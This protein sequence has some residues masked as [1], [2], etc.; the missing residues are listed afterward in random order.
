MEEKFFKTIE[1]APV[2]TIFRHVGADSD[3]LGSQF[4]LKTWICDTY[5]DKKVYA[6][7]EDIGSCASQYPSIDHID[8][9]TIKTSLA[10]ILDTA[11]TA[12]IDDERWI[13][14]TQ[15]MKIDHHIQVEKF[16]N[17]QIVKEAAGATCEIIATIFANHHEKIS[18][19]CAT[20][21]YSGLIADTLQFSIATTT[22]NTLRAAAYLADFD[23]DIPSIN[24]QNFTKSKKE[25]VYETYLRSHMVMKGEHIAYCIVT[26]K[27]YES[28]NLTLN[29]A[30]EKVYAFA[31]VKEFEIWALFVENG[32]DENGEILFNGSLRSA[33][34]PI[35]PIAN[36]YHGGGHKLACGVKSLHAPEIESLLTELVA[37]IA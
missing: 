24:K 5:P 19:Q 9:E 23:I 15:T 21:L 29:E 13:L 26:K 20:Y 6:L 17:I 14:A 1:K 31:N 3:A 22:S 34:Y 8:D 4:G 2:I 36:K 27:E 18:K 12:R 16:G 7:G 35:D 10:I 32:Q 25:Y 33:R 30:K 28:F 37:R 11:N